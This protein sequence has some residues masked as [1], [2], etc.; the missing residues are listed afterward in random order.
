MTGPEARSAERS[1]VAIL[2][3]GGDRP[4]ALGLAMSMV[5]RGIHF[6]FIGSDFLESS[7]LRQCPQAR[8]LNLR[9]DMRP[10]VPLW[11]KV[12]RVA[13]YYAQ[14]FAYALTARPKVFH[15]L[16]NNKFESFDRTLLILYYRILGKRIVLTVHNVNI[17]KRDG[18]DNS[19]NWFTL[20]VQY[21]LVDH[22]F[23]HTHQMQRELRDDFGVSES[24]ISVIPFGVNDTVPNTGMDRVEARRR[25]GL[26]GADKVILFYGNIAPYKGVTFLVDAFAKVAESLPECHLIVAGRPKGSKSYWASIEQRIAELRLLPKVVLRIEYIP[27]S[28]TEVYFKAAD[29]L[30]LPYTHIFQSGVLFL[31]YNFGIPVIASDVGSFKDDIIEGKTGL[32]CRP[33]DADDLARAITQFFGEKLPGSEFFGRAQIKQFAH[34]K[35]SWAAVAETTQRVYSTLLAPTLL[36]QQAPPDGGRARSD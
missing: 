30:C 14:L 35:Y 33:E 25:C 17:R 13:K 3:G 20:M 11:Q 9:G 19:W 23:V 10:E 31:G 26:D 7:E 5:A 4:Y 2:T 12:I 34:D 22:L 21:R 18:N 6:D 27:D 32:M 28:E 15:I 36:A 16:W 1:Q 8:F 29:V 24:A